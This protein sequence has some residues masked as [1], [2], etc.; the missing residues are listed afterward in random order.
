MN[1]TDDDSVHSHIKAI[2]EVF[3]SLSIVG[4]PKSD[5]DRIMYLL[6]CLPESYSMFV[7]ALEI[8]TEVP[9][10]ELVTAR[11]LHEGNN[12]KRR[13]EAITCNE[14]VMAAGHRYRERGQKWYNCGKF[15]H[16]KRNCRSNFDPVSSETDQGSKQKTL[17]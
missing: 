10:I 5:E 14:K 7:T 15:G 4:D 1:L 12:V 2:A 16:T 3:N 8:H 17:H 6:A 11:L 9:Q 13:E